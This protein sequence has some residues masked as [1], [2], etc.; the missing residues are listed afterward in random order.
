M[1]LKAKSVKFVRP[2]I[3]T[4]Q[5]LPLRPVY[6]KV[7]PHSQNLYRNPHYCSKLLFCIIP[8]WLKKKLSIHKVVPGRVMAEI[9]IFI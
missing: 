6:V 8:R 2:L 7:L 1:W 5:A 3:K 4:L 9:I